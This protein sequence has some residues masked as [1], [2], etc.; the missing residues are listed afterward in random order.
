MMRPRARQH[1]TPNSDNPLITDA[2]DR[3]EPIDITDPAEPIEPM[4]KT[5]PAEPT[6]SAEPRE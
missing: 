5:D 4:D 2:I 1:M 3:N 6:E